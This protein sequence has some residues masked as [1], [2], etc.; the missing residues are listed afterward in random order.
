MA[1]KR[2][3]LISLL[4]FALP[5]IAAP[6]TPTAGGAAVSQQKAAPPAAGAAVEDDLP[7]GAPRDDY[8]F[9]AWCYGLVRQHV[10]LYPRVK[11]EL[12]AISKRLDSAESD[13]KL[14]AETLNDHR[15]AM[16]VLA[17]A[18][19]AAERAS[20]RP[21]NVVGA[22]ARE[23]GRRMWDNMDTIDKSMQ[24]YSWMNF[25]VPDRC[26]RVA[27]ALETRSRL[28]GQALQA[29]VPAPAAARP[30]APAPTPAPK[31]A[32]AAPTTTSPTP[33]AGLR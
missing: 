10:E 33:P 25:G 19:E 3:L 26:N 31:A 7:T 12:D 21:I 9:T 8:E 28:F 29:N 27:V 20:P 30:A 14:W 5:A 15:Q 32:P 22:T 18:I 1:L 11:P 24:A 2:A 23:R 4:A 16:T 6:Q 17:R 13:A